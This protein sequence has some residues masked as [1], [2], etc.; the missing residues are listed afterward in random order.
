LVA[1]QS[2]P[3]GSFPDGEYRLEIKIS[4]NLSGKTITHKVQFFVTT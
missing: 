2:L 1:G 4:D 3:L